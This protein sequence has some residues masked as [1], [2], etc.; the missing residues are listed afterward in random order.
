MLNFAVLGVLLVPIYVVL[1]FI[2]IKKKK[3]FLE[4]LIFTTFY[5]YISL[6]IKV[7]IFQI[8]IDKLLLTHLHSVEGYPVNLIPFKSI[9][10]FYSDGDQRT[11]LKQVGGNILMFIP[12]G[13][14]IPL[15]MKKI[16]NLGKTMIIAI[17]AS[18]LIELTQAL[19]SSLIG[20]G[21][22]SVDVDDIILN[23]FGALI[24]YLFLRFVFLPILKKNPSLV[25]NKETSI[26]A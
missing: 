13:C 19:I 15:I 2:N 26:N 8:P 4:H 22:R 10:N 17:M 21:Y 3:T 1:L 6:V 14:Y 9:S 11:F 16:V 24:G 25:S 7:T 5:I 18:L 20:F 12:T 23:T